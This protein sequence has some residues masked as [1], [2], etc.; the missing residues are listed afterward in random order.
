MH[1]QYVQRV[2]DTFASYLEGETIR[3]HVGW[4]DPKHQSGVL[5][6]KVDKVECSA[7]DVH[8]ISG[9]RRFFVYTEENIEILD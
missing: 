4:F 6:L 1:E 9:G 8:I 5:D 2:E 3:A 7:V